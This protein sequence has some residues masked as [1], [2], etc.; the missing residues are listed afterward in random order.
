VRFPEGNVVLPVQLPC[1]PKGGQPRASPPRFLVNEKRVALDAELPGFPEVSGAGRDVGEQSQRIFNRFW[2]WCGY[3]KICFASKACSCSRGPAKE[4]TLFD[5]I[6][7]SQDLKVEIISLVLA[8]SKRW[9]PAVRRPTR[10]IS[11]VT[12]FNREISTA[13]KPHHPWQIKKTARTD[14]ESERAAGNENN[15]F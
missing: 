10:P 5:R 2:I 9:R 14:L 12:E 6:L 13:E 1:V 3:H 11:C 15:Y 4:T 7:H 8:A